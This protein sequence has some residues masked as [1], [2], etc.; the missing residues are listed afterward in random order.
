[1]IEVF[2]G[3]VEWKFEESLKMT[4]WEAQMHGKGSLAHN[5][6]LDY[7]LSKQCVT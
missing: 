1:M 5:L 6:I 3:N 2:Y 4:L 7:Q